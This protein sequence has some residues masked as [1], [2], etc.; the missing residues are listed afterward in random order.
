M[1]PGSV[2]RELLF[3]KNNSLVWVWICVVPT[4]PEL[5]HR[6]AGYAVGLGRQSVQAPFNIQRDRKK[7]SD[8]EG[9]VLGCFNFSVREKLR[10][11]SGASVQD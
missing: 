4:I 10:L 5:T 1:Y 2:G 8:F 11:I 3:N 7:C 6:S 9:K